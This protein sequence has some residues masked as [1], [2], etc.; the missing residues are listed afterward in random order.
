MVQTI[1]Q[2]LAAENAYDILGLPRDASSA[3]IKSAYREVAP[4]YPV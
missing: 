1:D 2:V 3:D 4:H